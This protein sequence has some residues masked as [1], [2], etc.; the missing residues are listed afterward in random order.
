MAVQP[1]VLRT[2]VLQIYKTMLRLSNVWIAK[3]PHQTGVERD[4]IMEETKKLFRSNQNIKSPH[5]IAERLREAEARLAMATH[6]HNPYP[7]PV[8]LPPRSF[9]KKAGKKDG[10]AIEKLNQISKPI[11][12][13]SIDD[14]LAK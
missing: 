1:Q 8:N 3:D 9:A 5:E 10:K 4:Y 11:Y 2:R 7:R 13:K 6:Y 14:T 12:V